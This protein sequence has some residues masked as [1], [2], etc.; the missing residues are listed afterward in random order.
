MNVSSNGGLQFADEPGGNVCS[1]VAVTTYNARRDEV[2]SAHAPAR[3]RGDCV[4]REP[5]FREK[6]QT[7]AVPFGAASRYL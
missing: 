3:I 2:S 6:W 4:G 7:G 5:L 1:Y